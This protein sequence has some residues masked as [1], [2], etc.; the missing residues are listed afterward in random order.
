MAFGILFSDQSQNGNNNENGNKKDSE[1]SDEKGNERGYQEDINEGDNKNNNENNN[2]SEYIEW[3]AKHGRVAVTIAILSG[4][5]IDVMLMLK[6]RLMGLNMFNAP[7]NDRSLEI[8]FWG[9]C[10]D[11]FLSDIPQFVIQILFIT[12]SVLLDPI[13]VFTLAA[14]GISILSSVISKLFFIKFDAVSPYLSR[15]GSSTSNPNNDG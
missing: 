4:T 6:S 12:A 2:E 15:N 8:I 14:S 10:A 13:P 1:N 7:F 9:A 3:F 5:N 11:I